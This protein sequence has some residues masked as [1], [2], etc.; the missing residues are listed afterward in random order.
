[1][2]E[3]KV[4]ARKITLKV[5]QKAADVTEETTYKFMGHGKVD[6]FN[7]TDN[8]PSATNDGALIAQVALKLLKTM[9]IPCEDL[10]G[11][12]IQ[13]T[14]LEGFGAQDL[15]VDR[16]QRKLDFAK[17]APKTEIAKEKEKAPLVKTS[18]DI[19]LLDVPPPAQQPKK[20]SRSPS[21][22]PVVQKTAAKKR[23]PSVQQESKPVAPKLDN[24][25]KQPML[26]LPT[27]KKGLKKG[28]GKAEPSIQTTIGFTGQ[29]KWQPATSK[30]LQRGKVTDA[31]L[32]EHD[33]DPS[34]YRSLPPAYQ[35]DCLTM[36]M[37][38]KREQNLVLARER[39]KYQ[40]FQA[41]SSLAEIPTQDLFDAPIP[42]EPA[43][44]KLLAIEDIRRRIDKWVE[45]DADDGPE[46]VDRDKLGSYLLACATDGPRGA[47][48]EKVTAVL[49]WWKWA[50]QKRAGMGK[51]DWLVAWAHVKGQVDEAVG[52]TLCV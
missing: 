6:N 48:L 8:L 52:C 11:I 38:Q 28:K 30:L 45:R 41:S 34:Y 4:T 1:M 33:I 39:L 37:E 36:A 20:R 46:P 40:R 15:T 10:R 44:G 2:K 49:Q 25:A 29:L 5:M 23:Q 50:V 31:D 18:S 3:I 26:A 7:A 42:A 12:G 22:S 51:E 14:K 16:G 47:N 19:V 17:A 35:S 13:M 21:S 24:N 27:T 43:F 32:I 9:H